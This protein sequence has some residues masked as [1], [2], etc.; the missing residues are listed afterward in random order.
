MVVPTAVVVV[1]RAI[2]HPELAVPTAALVAR[3]VTAEALANPLET[4]WRMF[5]SMLFVCPSIVLAAPLEAVLPLVA[6]AVATE[7]EV[8]RLILAPV[9]AAVTAVVVEADPAPKL[10]AAVAAATAVMAEAGLAPAAVAVADSLAVVVMAD[11]QAVCP[12]LTMTV[13][14]GKPD[15]AAAAVAAPVVLKPAMAQQAVSASST[16]RKEGATWQ[17]GM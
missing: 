17:S 11:K 15:M 10:A 7:A 9:V 13:L 3:L 8:A 16:T 4:L 6:V 5:Y 12:V 14:P 1:L 2:V